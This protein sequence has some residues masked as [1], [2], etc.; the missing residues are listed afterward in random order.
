M[1]AGV[2]RQ[3]SD[4]IRKAQSDSLPRVSIQVLI[5]IINRSRSRFTCQTLC[6]SRKWIEN[7]GVRI[8]LSSGISS[9]IR[10][11]PP[12]VNGHQ[13]PDFVNRSKPT[14]LVEGKCLPNVNIFTEFGEISPQHI[15]HL[16]HEFIN[17]PEYK[18]SSF[19][20]LM[21]QHYMKMTDPR[22]DSD[23]DA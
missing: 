6:H 22:K 1:H 3:A 18:D 10:E 21:Q 23:D 16:F 9:P 17:W 12:V 20:S 2:L 4:V 14:L 15:F 7:C 13:L 11:P 5:P 8:I 19:V